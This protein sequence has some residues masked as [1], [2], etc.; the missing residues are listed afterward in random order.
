MRRLRGHGPYYLWVIFTARGRNLRRPA[1]RE[2]GETQGSVFFF[3][4]K[5]KGP[6][7]P[8]MFSMILNSTH[9]ARL[10]PIF[11]TNPGICIKS[12]VTIPRWDPKQ[13]GFLRLP[14]VKNSICSPRVFFHAKR[15]GK[16]MVESFRRFESSANGGL[17]TALCLQEATLPK[18]RFSLPPRNT[19]VVFIGQG[20]ILNQSSQLKPPE[21]L[22][23][24]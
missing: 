6:K 20:P 5:S 18:F 22:V 8:K 10:P 14:M 23:Y 16:P 15:C 2:N 4:P 3:C 19:V 1:V 21:R 24:L 17:S 12:P 9:D 11:Q 7:E 13:L